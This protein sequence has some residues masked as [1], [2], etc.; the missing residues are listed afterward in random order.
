MNE[1]TT[2]TNE[3]REL[4]IEL[5][6]AELFFETGDA[7]SV[8]I[9]QETDTNIILKEDGNCLS[10]IDENKKKYITFRTL[11]TKAPIIRL[12]VPS[13]NQFDKVLIQTGAGEFHIDKLSTKRLTLEMGAGEFSANELNVSEHASIESGAGEVNIKGG[14]I[15]NL[16]FSSG[17]GQFTMCAA[18]FGNSRLIAGVGEISLHLLGNPTDYTATVTKAIGHLSVTGFTSYNGRTYGDGPNH[19]DITGGIGEISLSI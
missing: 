17:A 8:S 15:H 1:F 14:T 2:I 11:K 6:Y 13:E 18:L 7:F 10:V 16:N 19:I 4:H 9:E 3:I 5:G 12:T